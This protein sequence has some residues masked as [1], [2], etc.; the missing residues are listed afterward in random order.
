MELFALIRRD[1]RVEGLSVRALA[2][3][4]GAHRR[5]VRQALGSAVPPARKAPARSSPVTGPLREAMDEMLRADLDAP[6]KQRH[7]AHRIWERLVDEHDAKIAY[8][9]VS[10]Y[11]A[12]RRPQ[13]VLEARNRANVMDGFVPQ[14]HLPGQDAEVDF[15]EV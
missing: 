8:R 2:D 14:T 4:H 13:I 11:V 7:T 12:K 9:T 6:R 10:K 15:A 5:T 1:S 3:R